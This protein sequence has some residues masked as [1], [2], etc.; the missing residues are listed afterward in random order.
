MVTANIDLK[1]S[2]WSA[3]RGVWDYEEP[4]LWGTEGTFYTNPRKECSY[5]SVTLR[6][7]GTGCW[8]ADVD[9]S[10]EWDDESTT[11]VR[12]SVVALTYQELMQAID[13]VE[14]DLLNADAKRARAWELNGDGRSEEENWREQGLEFA[15]GM[16]ADF[17]LT[18]EKAEGAGWAKPEADYDG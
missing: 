3:D 18:L 9:F 12:K 5:G 15:D 4:G 1:W 7:D 8:Y 16:N 14:Y 13:A 10:T 2:L 17:T 6:K 11:N